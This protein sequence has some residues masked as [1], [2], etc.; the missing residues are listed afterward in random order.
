[1]RIDRVSKRQSLVR[2]DA[3]VWLL[4]LSDL[5]ENELNEFAVKHSSYDI[6]VDDMCCIIYCYNEEVANFLVL[7]YS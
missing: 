5:R 7:K 6:V 3:M 4:Y 1:M 2:Y